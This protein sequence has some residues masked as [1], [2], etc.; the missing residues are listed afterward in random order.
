MSIFTEQPDGAAIP[1]VPDLS[2]ASML[3][4]LDATCGQYAAA[5]K[6]EAQWSAIIL[7]LADAADL[8]GS[9]GTIRDVASVMRDAERARLGFPNS[10]VEPSEPPA[11]HNLPPETRMDVRAIAAETIVAWEAALS[12]C[13]SSSLVRW[14]ERNVQG[15]IEGRSPTPYPHHLFD[16]AGAA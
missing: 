6:A 12:P 2:P 10:T 9:I 8:P 13:L 14:V 4:R 16:T 3:N 11:L 5:A 15:V 1:G 7:W